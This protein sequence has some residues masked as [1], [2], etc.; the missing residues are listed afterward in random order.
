MEIIQR[1]ILKYPSHIKYWL[2]VLAI[3]VMIIAIK[4]YLNYDSILLE[5]DEVKNNNNKTQQQILY[6]KNFLVPYLSSSY[7]DYFLAHENSI[8]YKTEQ[9]IKFEFVD[10]KVESDL[11]GWNTENRSWNTLSPQ[12][13]WNKFIVSKLGK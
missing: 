2:L 5:I 8:L 12:E 10:K 13:S 6:T 1:L 11:T 3:F 4:N 9:V 7:A